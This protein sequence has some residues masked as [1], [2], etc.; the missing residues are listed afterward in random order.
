MPRQLSM[1]SVQQLRPGML[2]PSGCPAQHKPAPLCTSTR[3]SRHTW[4]LPA[5]NP[6]P[7][8]NLIYPP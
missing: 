7:S 1:H 3:A 6:S 8:I 4:S 2:R 5:G